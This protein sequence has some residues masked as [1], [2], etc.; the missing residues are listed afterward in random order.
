MALLSAS[1]NGT[2][3]D[4][5][6]SESA[7]HGVEVAALLKVSKATVYALIESGRL[8]HFRVLNSIR[9]RGED[10]SALT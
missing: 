9:V 5:T 4:S 3:Q 7:L 6:D 8:P 2:Q 10:F 1:P